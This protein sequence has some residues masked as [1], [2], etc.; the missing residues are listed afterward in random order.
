MA[1]NAHP[2]AK[3]EESRPVRYD[4]T[5]RVGKT[6][7]VLLYVPPAGTDEDM[8]KSRLGMD[9]VVLVGKNTIKYNDLLGMTREVPIISRSTI[10]PKATESK[11]EKER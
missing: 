6:D 3:G 11:A 10:T 1:V 5:F 9:I 4:V 8:I 2:P 7:Y